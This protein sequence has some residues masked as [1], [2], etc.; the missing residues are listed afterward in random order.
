MQS[1]HSELNYYS[2]NKAIE[3]VP[4]Q[5]DRANTFHYFI[6]SY[7]IQNN[8]IISTIFYGTYENVTKCNGCQQNLY[9]FQKFEFI[10]FGMIDYVGK[11]FDIYNGFKDNEKILKLSGDNQFYCNNCKKLNDAET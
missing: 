7:D 4:N 8:S 2:K 10:S 1:M 11:D 5:F 3:G 9:N 6:K